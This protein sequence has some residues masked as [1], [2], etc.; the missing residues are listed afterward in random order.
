MNSKHQVPICPLQAFFTEEYSRDH[1]ED[2]EKLSH[3]KD[4]IAWQVKGQKSILLLLPGSLPLASIRLAWPD[5]TCPPS[6]FS[7][8]DSG[9]PGQAYLGSEVWGIPPWELPRCAAAVLGRGVAKITLSDGYQ[10]Q[11]MVFLSKIKMKPKLPPSPPPPPPAGT[12]W[13]VTYLIFSHPASPN[14]TAPSSAVQFVAD[15]ESR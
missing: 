9:L 7:F 8:T 13:I 11:E 4:L 12:S 5:S 10:T 14:P 15:G 2:Q 3:L 6:F 1:P